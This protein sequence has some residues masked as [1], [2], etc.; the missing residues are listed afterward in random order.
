MGLVDASDADRLFLAYWSKGQVCHSAGMETQVWGEKV[1]SSSLLKDPMR[2]ARAWRKYK[3]TCQQCKQYLT[4]I[5]GLYIKPDF[6]Y[7]GGMETKKAIEMAG[8]VI[9]LA[10]LLG[11][12]RMAVYQWGEQV[13]QARLWQLKVIKPEWFV[14]Q[15]EKIV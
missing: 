15:P 4:R 14:E 9:K 6:H 10:T 5:K 8:S 2:F 1:V 12:S 7:D 13:P 11:I 3:P